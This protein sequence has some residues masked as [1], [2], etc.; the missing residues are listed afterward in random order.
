V[1]HLG[2]IS[3]LLRAAAEEASR[4]GGSLRR[5]RVRLGALASLDE[6]HF[7]EDFGLA[8]EQLGMTRVELEVERAPDRPSGVEL[9]GIEV[10]E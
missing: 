10:A 2:V 6:A 5:V 1:H 8:R 3:K 7:R 4:R 9:V